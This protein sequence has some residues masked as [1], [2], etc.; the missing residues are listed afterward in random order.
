M[1]ATTAARLSRSCWRCSAHCS[2]G[3]WASHGA[4]R[5][6]RIRNQL[7]QAL[8]DRHAGGRRNPNRVA[9]HRHRFQV[10]RHQV[11]A[12]L[13]GRLVQYRHQPSPAWVGIDGQPE[14]VRKV[15]RHSVRA[16]DLPAWLPRLV[17]ESVL[18]CAAEALDRTHALELGTY[19]QRVGR[20]VDA[21][22]RQVPE[23][24]LAKRAMRHVEE[25]VV[26][27]YAA[28]PAARLPVQVGLQAEPLVF[29]PPGLSPVACP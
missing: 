20:P 28:T 3:L 15:T 11:G 22:V 5:R 10:E 7:A 29:V 26:L 16:R 1:R 21:R 24:D 4:V 19:R 23:Q 12:A 8:G 14:V 13:I 6:V 18:W 2:S 25:T 27:A 9:Q 17:I